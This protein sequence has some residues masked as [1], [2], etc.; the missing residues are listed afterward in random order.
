MDTSGT[1]EGESDG[2]DFDV[3]L[4]RLDLEREHGVARLLKK[5][6]DRLYDKLNVESSE[7]LVTDGHGTFS[8]APSHPELEWRALVDRMS[9]LRHHSD[10]PRDLIPTEQSVPDYGNT[11][12][13]DKSSG[14]VVTQVQLCLACALLRDLDA[15]FDYQDKQAVPAS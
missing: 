14:S 11:Q 9:V 7:S 1:A 13:E 3:A 6:D 12:E 4:A 8:V 10:A 5:L 15:A 2:E